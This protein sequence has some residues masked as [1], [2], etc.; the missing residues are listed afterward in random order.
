MEEHGESVAACPE[1]LERIFQRLEQESERR[2]QNE[3]LAVPAITSEDTSSGSTTS[4]SETIS[5]S[6]TRRRASIS[7]TRFG[8]LDSESLNS[9]SKPSS[10]TV[11]SAFAMPIYQA[12]VES[13]ST[14]TLSSKHSEDDAHAHL[15][16]DDHV[17]Q[18]H[19]IAARQS[20]SR[21]I[22]NVIPRRL[23]RV[24]SRPVFTEGDTTNSMVI[25]ISVQAAT[26]E[27][28]AT[29]DDQPPSTV[30]SAA[31]SLKGKSSKSSLRSDNGSGGGGGGGG[32]W[33]AR[34]KSFTN[35][36]RRKS[37]QQLADPVT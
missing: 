5:R 19:R 29:E 33:V 26:M 22:G 32:G 2:A 31:A 23:S 30:V 16:D 37:R 36:L 24:R 11:M 17:T 25:G 21:A 35:K 14:D 9:P 7:I 13:G 12:R 6:R 4:Q 27:I 28:P 8:Q 10:P 3:L 1:S 15:E 18:V 20:I 34:A